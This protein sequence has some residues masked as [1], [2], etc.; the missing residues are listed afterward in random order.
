MSPVTLKFGED[1]R[2]KLL[3]GAEKL[4]TAVVATLGPWGRNAS[5]RRA[6]VQ[7]QNGNLIHIPPT[8]TKDG[9]F[10]ARKI[11]SFADPFEDMGA[12]IVKEAAERTNRIAGDGTTTATLLA[13]EMMKDGALLLKEGANAIHI[14]RGMLKAGNAVIAVLESMRREVTGMD[15]LQ[16]IASISSQ[17][18]EIGS[19]VAMVINE[20]GRDGA[21]QI[22][23]GMG[24]GLEYEITTGMQIAAGYATPYFAGKNGMA[25]LLSPYILVTTEKITS[26]RTILPIIKSIKEKDEK[27]CLVIF[28]TGVEGDALTTLVKNHLEGNADFLVLKPPFYGQRQTDILE[29]IAIATGA[30]LIDR[31]TGR[32]VERMTVNDLGTSESVLAS[33][34][35]STIVGLHGV[36][37]KRDDRIA[38]IKGALEAATEDPE[39]DFL[40]MRLANIAGKI[41]RIRVGGSSEVEQKEKQHRVEDAVVA[42]RAAFE[43][44]ILPGGGVAYLRCVAKLWP[45]GM[46]MSGTKDEIA[47]E[48]L[49]RRALQQQLWWVSQNAGEDPKTV[50]Q[51]VLSMKDTE[52]YN[53]ETGEYGDMF[54]MKVIDPLRVPVTALRNAVSVASLFLTTEVAICEEDLK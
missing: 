41:A 48:V 12:Q 42:T 2:Q 51:K 46:E 54:E 32:T 38:L 4:A 49:V 35:V 27:A 6:P 33:A 37:S 28:S 3:T 8:I 23:P 10:V 36:T 16:A 24:T 20:V 15:D 47:G 53:A 39:K 44:G 50:I 25:Q 17:D 14:R 22:V 45:D 1:A 26:I 7:D 9:V 43:T 13:Y 18:K 21:V 40:A 11:T 34:S 52:G 5:I 19:L 29:D 31:K 30:T